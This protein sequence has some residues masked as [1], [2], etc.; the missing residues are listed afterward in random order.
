[1]MKTVVTL[2]RHGETE[3]NTKGKFQGC[4]DI[5]LTEDGIGQAKLV[6]KRLDGKFDCVYTS[7]LK[8]AFHTAKIISSVKGIDP[9]IEDELREIN[10]GKWEGLTVNDIRSNFTKEFE[11]WRSDTEEGPICGGDL[12]T[13]NAS[14]RAKASILKI[15]GANR[16]KHIII[17][18]H[19]GI[20]KAGLIGLFDWNMTMYHKLILG[21][22]AICKLEFDDD[23]NP[24]IITINDTNH[25]IGEYE[26]KD[27][28][29]AK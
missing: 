16:G 8:R 19:G 12:S 25:L 9:I 15:V 1:M 24:R 29:E 11:I 2:I 3:W 22:T 21:N 18:A 23:N 14:L 6:S 27:P 20:I 7:P 13:K 10:F 26:V 28:N 5:D 4:H 17:V